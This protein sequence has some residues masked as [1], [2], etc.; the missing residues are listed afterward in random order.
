M[1][2]PKLRTSV[3]LLASAA[4]KARQIETA[5]PF[6][7][8]DLVARPLNLSLPGLETPRQRSASLEKRRPIFKGLQ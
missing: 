8:A 7:G 3:L 2:N 4:F 5:Q 6:V 1:Q